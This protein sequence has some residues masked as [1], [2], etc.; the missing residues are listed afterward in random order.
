MVIVNPEN[1]V[2]HLSLH[3]VKT[4]FM[5]RLRQLPETNQIIEVLDQAHTSLTFKTFYMDIIDINLSKLAR[6]RASYVF[7]GQGTL[8]TELTDHQSIRQH[9]A[10]H[11]E[12][13]GYID[14]QYV[15]DTVKVVFIWPESPSP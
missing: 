11:N 1:P 5:G 14:S 7:S 12:S 13:I 10:Q 3:E 2:N 9:V 6:Y 15:N 8:P 4:I